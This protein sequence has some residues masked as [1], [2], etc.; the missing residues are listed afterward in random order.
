LTGFDPRFEMGF[1][2]QYQQ[3]NQ[4]RSVSPVPS[5]YSE[6]L[7]DQPENSPD[8]E[9]REDFSSSTTYH[10][11][12]NYHD[13]FREEE[14]RWSSG[15]SSPNPEHVYGGIMQPFYRISGQMADNMSSVTSS[16]HKD[17]PTKAQSR[18]MKQNELT[19]LRDLLAEGRARYSG[20]KSRDFESNLENQHRYELTV[21]DMLNMMPR[22]LALRP[23][24]Q[25]KKLALDIKPNIIRNGH[26]LVERDIHNMISSMNP[27]KLY[28][29]PTT[30]IF[31]ERKLSAKKAPPPLRLRH[32]LF[33]TG[34]HPLKSPFPFRQTPGVPETIRETGSPERT[35]SKRISGAMKNLSLSPT[36]PTRNVISNGARRSNG[37]D[38][39]M[40]VKS[41]FNFFP[42]AETTM[43]KG[44]HIQEAVTKVKKTVSFKTS[45]ERKRKSLKKSIVYVGISDQ[46]PGMGSMCEW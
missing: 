26:G 17:R 15:D 1:L 18:E 36:S 8:I 41:P 45:E 22:P 9:K 46:S 42:S 43:Q 21:A 27:P 5:S 16:Q 34:N 6:S 28:N 7:Y 3:I 44:G 40:P 30:P 4:P 10:Q 20:Q 25:T 12:E 19:T 23:K 38:T 31:Y 11:P 39:P 13:I 37:P 2:E 35:F 33:G 29:T 14:S 24:K 32:K